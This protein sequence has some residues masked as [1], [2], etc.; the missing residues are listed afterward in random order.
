LAGYSRLYA[1]R[2]LAGK[3]GTPDAM[4]G[5]PG[6]ATYARDLALV[7]QLIP[8]AFAG[9]MGLPDEIGDDRKIA[10]LSAE[11][12]ETW[13]KADESE[14]RAA[15]MHRLNELLDAYEKATGDDGR[16]A[17]VTEMTGIIAEERARI[18]AI[19]EGKRRELDKKGLVALSLLEAKIR[20]S[21]AK[22]G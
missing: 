18:M 19:P 15:A 4:T 12:G 8:A 17:I 9:A 2:G 14:K 3:P 5:Q 20:G 16:R 13:K 11:V 22:N 7:R 21:F 1:E 6:T 10:K